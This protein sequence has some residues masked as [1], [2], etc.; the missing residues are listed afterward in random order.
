[1]LVSLAIRAV[2]STFANR[3]LTSPGAPQSRIGNNGHRICAE[4]IFWI[5]VTS[6][7][8]DR[9]REKWRGMC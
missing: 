9:A 8:A 5:N 4:A 6:A 7:A 3:Q 1:M 2:S